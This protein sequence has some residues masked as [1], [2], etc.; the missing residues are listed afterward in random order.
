MGQTAKDQ[1][2]VA[3]R[4]KDIVMTLSRIQALESLGFKRKKGISKKSSPVDDAFRVRERIVEPPRLSGPAD[5][6]SLSHAD[7]L[8]AGP[9]ENDCLVAAQKPANSRQGAESQLETAVSNENLRVNQVAAEPR[10]HRR[11]SFTHALLL[12]E[13]STANVDR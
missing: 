12:G 6:N 13:G 8:V 7:V 2:Q 3:P 10:Q 1:L 4:R 5:Q 9:P 11:N